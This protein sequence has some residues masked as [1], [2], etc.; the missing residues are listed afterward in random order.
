MQQPSLTSVLVTIGVLVLIVL[1]NNRPRRMSVIALWIMPAIL[2]ALSL[3]V[4]WGT[5]MAM[6]AGIGAGIVACLIGLVA[7]IPLGYARGLHSDVRLGERPGT[8]VLHPS[9][10]VM[11]IWVGAFGLRYALRLMIPNAG[12]LT[13]AATDGLLVFAVSSYIVANVMIFRKYQA[14]RSA[15]AQGS[16][17]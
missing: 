11:L 14:L 10:I 1:R 12:P 6:P 9:V 8:F 16:P 3:F 2:T 17:A 7:G 15:A 13:F 5:A 4:I